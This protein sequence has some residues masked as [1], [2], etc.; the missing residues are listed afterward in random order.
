MPRLPDVIELSGADGAPIRVRV[1]QHPRARR[2]T[3]SLPL[4]GPRLVVPPRISAE[5]VQGFLAE[6]IGWLRRKSAALL[7][8][9]QGGGAIAPGQSESLSL[10]GKRLA[11]TWQQQRFPRI[12]IAPDTF[13]IGLDLNLARAQAI[14]HSLVESHLRRELKRDTLRLVSD[15]APRVGRVPT[16][17]RLQVLRS[18][19]GS[20]SA[21]GRMNL[22]LALILA[23]TPALEYVIAHEMCHLWER[24][25][26]PRFW[27]RVAAV[28]PEF[29]SQRDWLNQYGAA[30][31]LELARWTG[32]I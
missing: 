17:Y 30:T 20:M 29:E 15:L 5:M 22:D 11:V 19:W 24:N 13:T 9:G 31:K 27:A 32:R 1:V 8:S 12:E 16:A 6:H 3:L 28:C 10:R 7:R 21:S 4:E 23:P 14:C 18:L 25:H 26:G 2:M